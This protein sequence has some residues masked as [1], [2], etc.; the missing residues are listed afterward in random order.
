MGVQSDGE[1]PQPTVPGPY[2]GSL[3]RISNQRFAENT[4]RIDRF[5]AAVQQ[6]TQPAR[7]KD[8]SEW[9]DTEARRERKRAE[10][11]RKKAQVQRER[12]GAADG[13]EDADVQLPLNAD[14]T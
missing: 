7:K 4:K 13:T 8:G 12:R 11:L 10:G 14:I 6:A 5:R 3:V 9:E 2:L 1:P